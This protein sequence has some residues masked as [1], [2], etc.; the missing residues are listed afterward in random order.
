MPTSRSA[1]VRG[2]GVVVYGGIT[3]FCQEDATVQ[4]R[5]KMFDVKVEGEAID[6]RSDYADVLLTLT[7]MCAFTNANLAVLYPWTAFQRGKSLIGA[8]DLPL[9]LHGRD[10]RKLTL[11]N[12]AVEKQPPLILSA[13]KLPFGPMQFRGVYANNTAPATTGS[14]YTETNETYTYPAPV[15]SNFLTQSWAPVWG[16]S[17]PWNSFNTEDGIMIDFESKVTE[18]KDDDQGVY[19]LLFESL[20]VSAKMLPIGAT[21]AQALTLANLQRARGASATKNNLVVTGAD[22]SV[23]TLNA[24]ESVKDVPLLWH[25][26]KRRVGEIYFST[27]R[28]VVSSALGPIFAVAGAS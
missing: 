9:V 10:G 17:A 3:M 15:A 14:L 24:A 23:V 6:D 26:I 16:G 11:A 19:D 21:A 4:L 22:G 20:R 13:G 27:Q 1:D 2:A 7:P 12:A 28:Q 25:A 18:V 5:P 8:T